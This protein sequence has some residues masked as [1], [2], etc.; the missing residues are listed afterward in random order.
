MN[1]AL[2]RLFPFFLIL[3]EFCTN[4][5]NDMY[6]PAL[7]LIAKD[8]A[9][10][11]H[12]IQLTIVSWL[13]GNTSVQLLIGPLSDR[14]GRRAILLAG[15][16]VFLLSTLGCALAPSVLILIIARFLQGI[17]VCTMMVAGYAS[18]HDLY[19][20][21]KAIHILVWMGSA[22]VI[23]PAIG[24][25]FGGLLLLITG[26][27]AIFW[28]LAILSALSIVALW[29]SM[30]E[31]TKEPHAMKVK[32]I[33]ARYRRIF[34]NPD[35][36]ISSASFGLLYG[37]VIGWITA[38][39]F[40]LMGS[41]KL[42]PDLF[43]YLQIP[44]FCAYIV[45][46]RFVRYLLN[47]VGQETLI[48]WGEAIAL[49]AGSLL[50]IFAAIAP[51]SLYSFILPMACYTAG[52]GLASAPLNRTTMT[53]TKEQKGSAMAMFYLTMMGCG[54]LV[55]LSLSLIKDAI[56]YACSVIAITAFLS[57]VLNV[58]RRNLYRS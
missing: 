10:Q 53:A 11:L 20:D 25:V 31:S 42:S 40:I 52:F 23:A 46:A 29:F 47:I 14:Y 45:G 1:T 19:D 26:W 12:V 41:L 57:L 24:P 50:A 43:G 3:Y 21:Q 49:C 13:A 35:F 28:I 15:G 7:P 39:P 34:F 54:T 38:S 33:L 56:F 4:M 51:N 17:G 9:T 36:M 58:I 18:I 44:V 22:A 5:S 2:F 6:L 48:L 37:G 8:F 30:P 27:R 55:S 16:G 32:T